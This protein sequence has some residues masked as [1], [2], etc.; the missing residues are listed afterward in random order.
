MCTVK[1]YYILA[2]RFRLSAVRLPSLSWGNGLLGSGITFDVFPHV[3]CTGRFFL[4]FINI[5]Y[6][7]KIHVDD[8]EDGYNVAAEEKHL[9]K[10]MK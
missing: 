10:S 7:N 4:L 5:I 8:L 9:Y 3:F 1:P 6:K 2:E